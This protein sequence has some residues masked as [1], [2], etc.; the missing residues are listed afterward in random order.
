MASFVTK[1]VFLTL[2]LASHF[3]A[4]SAWAQKTV[5]QAPNVLPNSNSEAAA[6]PSNERQP[7]GE[8][9]PA[10][11]PRAVVAAMPEVDVVALYP[12]SVR[13]RNPGRRLEIRSTYD[14][15]IARCIGSC[16]LNLPHGD[17]KAIFYDAAE[18]EHAFE[19]TVDGQGGFE[20]DDAD[21]GTAKVG[22]GMGIAGVALVITGT[23][24]M[25][26]GLSNACVV[27]ECE[28]RDNSGGALFVGGLLALA[29][30]AAITPVGWVMW[31]HNRHPRL[32][33]RS[34]DMAV[35]VAPTQAGAFL[36]VTGH[37]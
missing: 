10:T 31:A 28:N 20:I 35:V 27:S 29:A 36:G 3:F 6:E 33:E 4:V 5:P 22:L 7:A 34:A 18:H 19:F 12:F 15:T 24:L 8:S 11:A 9:E 2:F 37:F 17:Y 21:E 14:V 30:G 1:S 16:R 13:A 23:A 26:A 25:T 32:L